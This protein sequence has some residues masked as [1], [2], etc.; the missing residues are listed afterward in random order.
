MGDCPAVSIIMAAHNAERYIGEAIRSV[1]NQTLRDF[2]L[3][4]RDDASTDGTRAIAARSG[5]PR[6]RLL[7]QTTRVGAAQARNEAFA[8]A[9]GRFIAI[10]DADDI[11]EPERLQR[12]LAYLE[13]HPDVAVVATYGLV[14]DEH[15]REME[16]L[17]P[18]LDPRAIREYAFERGNPCVHASILFRAG[19]LQRVKGYDPRFHTAHDHDLVLRILEHFQLANLPEPLYRVRRHSRS[20]SALYIMQ[21]R[22]YAELAR[23]MSRARRAG[24]DPDT[25]ARAQEFAQRFH[26]I[27]AGVFSRDFRCY[28][29]RERA[30]W[31]MDHGMSAKAVGH[32]IRAIFAQGVNRDNLWMLRKTALSCFRAKPLPV[33]SKKGN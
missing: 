26:D 5:D 3:L 30:R 32:A 21:Q 22:A 15:G 9:R 27:E 20:L 18:P 8:R 31:L 2:E 25:G 29:H 23:D 1:L 13:Q 4:I 6:I 24:E 11:S 16:L 33:E 28:V 7:P 14:V 17:E 19:V 10:H 12:Q